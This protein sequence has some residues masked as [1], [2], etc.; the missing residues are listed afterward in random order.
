MSNKG[1]FPDIFQ[2]LGSISAVRDVHCAARNIPPLV[3]VRIHCT[4][5]SPESLTHPQSFQIRLN[6]EVA[7]HLK[8]RQNVKAMSNLGKC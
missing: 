7:Y 2:A 5:S 6:L 1:V 4:L 3:S 8:L